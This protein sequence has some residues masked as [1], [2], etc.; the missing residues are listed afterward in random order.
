MG[1]NCTNFIGLG[2]CPTLRPAVC[3]NEVTSQ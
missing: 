1:N 2:Q 3:Y